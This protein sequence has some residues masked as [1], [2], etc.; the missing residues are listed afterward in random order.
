MAPRLKL[1]MG[2]ERVSKPQ[3]A[4]QSNYVALINRQMAAIRDSLEDVMKQFEDATPEITLEAMRPT[5]EKSQHYVPKDTMD[6]HNSGYL[7]ITSFRG[8]PR[9]EMGYA[10]GGK[11]DY[12]PY[13]HE[14]TSY[15]HASPT[16]SKFL[17]AAVD[18][19]LS[20]M[21]DRLAEGYRRFMNG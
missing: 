2:L 16:R 10:K 20:L 19:D 13:V 8:S 14:I 15:A 1:K 18:E 11:P 6:L 12:A 7:E 4:S 17:Q 9:I 3:Y 21:A 5:F